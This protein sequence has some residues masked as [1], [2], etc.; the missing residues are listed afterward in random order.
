[1]ASD[2]VQVGA[3][4]SAAPHGRPSLGTPAR[5]LTGPLEAR[6]GGLP[7]ALCSLLGPAP[8]SPF[9]APFSAGGGTKGGEV[10]EAP[11]APSSSAPPREFEGR[12]GGPTS[13]V[14]LAVRPG[15]CCPRHCPPLQR[16]VPGRCRSTWCRCLAQ[17]LRR[18]GGRPARALPPHNKAPA[19]PASGLSFM[20]VPTPP[21]LAPVGGSARVTSLGLG[22]RDPHGHPPGCHV[23]SD[24]RW[25]VSGSIGWGFSHTW[26]PTW[27]WV[28][29]R[30][31]HHHH[32]HIH[33]QRHR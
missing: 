28:A 7:S 6:A 17:C 8:W 18:R 23:E 33:T 22:T 2:A 19:V 12:R 3:P 13:G 9:T 4:V 27:A 30:S 32:T 26:T 16:S 10:L 29:R 24:P 31:A 21:R 5:G 20:R 25:G 1:M 14:R 11:A 15:A